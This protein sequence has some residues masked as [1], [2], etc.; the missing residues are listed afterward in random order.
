MDDR[1]I[2]CLFNSFT[3]DKATA[4][5]SLQAIHESR[6]ANPLMELV[7]VGTTI[8]AEVELQAPEQFNGTRQHTTGFWIKDDAD[9]ASVMERMMVDCKSKETVCSWTSTDRLAARLVSDHSTENLANTCMSS[10]YGA[11]Y[12]VWHSQ[13]EDQ[14]YMSHHNGIMKEVHRHSVG[15]CLGDSDFQSF[16]TK[17]WGNAAGRKLM[18]LRKKWDP[19]GRICGYLDSGD[20]SGIIGLE[21]KIVL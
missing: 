13:D 14:K 8:D 10:H 15:G 17:Y 11:L 9:V 19:K 4:E 16:E 7:C 6:P 21:N 2:A 20:K 18:E 1:L 12:T 5:K 3:P